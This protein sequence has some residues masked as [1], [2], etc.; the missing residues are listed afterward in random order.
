VV[1]DKR[2]GRPNLT[3]DPRDVSSISTPRKHQPSSGAVKESPYMNLQDPPTPSGRLSERIEKLRER[4][5]D[6][7][8]R[9]AFMAAYSFLK[10]HEDV[11]IH[12]SRVPC[13]CTHLHASYLH[14]DILAG[15]EPFFYHAWLP[16]RRLLTTGACT[17]MTLK[18]RSWSAFARY[19]ARENRTTRH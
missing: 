18:S 6:A 11:R 15:P 1:P 13:I 7:L 14:I 4:C 5:I 2:P 8:G 9:D 12:E 19:S 16:H 17:R 10:Q 3:I